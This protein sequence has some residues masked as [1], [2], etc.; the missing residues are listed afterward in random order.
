MAI[1]DICPVEANPHRNDRDDDGPMFPHIAWGAGDQNPEGNDGQDEQEPQNEENG[2]PEGQ[3]APEG[4]A[5][6]KGNTEPQANEVALPRVRRRVDV[7]S[8][9]KRLVNQVVPL[10]DLVLD[11]LTF[12]EISHLSPC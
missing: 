12:V 7:D 2:N 1:G 5:D 4:Q 3:A 6:P 10:L 8:I 11:W 9:S